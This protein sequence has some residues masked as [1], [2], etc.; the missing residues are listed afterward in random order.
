MQSSV[1]SPVGRA[2]DFSFMPWG[3]HWFIRG[4]DRIFLNL[5]PVADQQSDRT[6]K[7]TGCVPFMATPIIF[8]SVDHSVAC[9]IPPMKKC[10]RTR[11]HTHALTHA[12]TYTPTHLQAQRQPS[13]VCCSFSVRTR[14]CHRSNQIV[15]PT[16]SLVKASNRW[17]NTRGGARR[18][19]GENKGAF[20]QK[21]PQ[22]GAGCIRVHCAFA[23]KAG[24]R[25]AASVFCLVQVCARSL[26]ALTQ[27]Q[28]FARQIAFNRVR[29]R[30]NVGIRLHLC[31]VYK[32]LS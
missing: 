22:V 20:L 17:F 28:A 19:Q 21:S 25:R 4:V 9:N 30:K 1:S 27:N 7:K 6:V 18:G 8:Y 26:R 31:I 3:S 16:V 15:A 23:P 12:H 32:A 24:Q 29:P 13:I 14:L 2:S 11:T 5:W 10:T